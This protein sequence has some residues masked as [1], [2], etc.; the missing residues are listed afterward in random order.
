MAYK[1]R[2]VKE[3]RGKDQDGKENAE[4]STFH[5]SDSEP[6]ELTPVAPTGDPGPNAF[7]A[8]TALEG[9]TPRPRHCPPAL[10]ISAAQ[11]IRVPLFQVF[12]CGG[13]ERV[14][15]AA[16]GRRSTRA[17]STHACRLNVSSAPQRDSSV[18][19]GERASSV[20]CVQG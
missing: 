15:C 5:T 12:S 14:T 3:S 8:Q 18:G 19:R 6:L 20:A 11:S 9:Q 13:V 17:P 7:E 4:G 2:G 10:A 16:R 1:Q